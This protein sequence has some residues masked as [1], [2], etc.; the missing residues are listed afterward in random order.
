[1][2]DKLYL[3]SIVQYLL[4][5]AEYEYCMLITKYNNSINC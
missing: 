2:V 3:Y 5:Q 1:M 4:F